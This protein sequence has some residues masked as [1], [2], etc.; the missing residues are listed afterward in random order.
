MLN[1]QELLRRVERC[2][3]GGAC[4]FTDGI[5]ELSLVNPRNSDGAIP[6]FKPKCFYFG[7]VQIM[8]LS[9]ICREMRIGRAHGENSIFGVPFIEVRERNHFSVSYLHEKVF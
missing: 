8:E 4:V 9:A 5:E 1:G 6:V 3:F 2:V 7:Y